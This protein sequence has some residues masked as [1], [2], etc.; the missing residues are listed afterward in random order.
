MKK[1]LSILFLCFLFTVGAQSTSANEVNNG[2]DTQE[3]LVPLADPFILLDGQTYYAYGTHS[4]RGIEVYRSDN[5]KDWSY[6]GLAL[7]KDDSYGDKWFWAPEV[8]NVNGKYY[9]YYSADEHICVAT[10]D[11]PRGPFRQLIQKPMMT[12]EK[13]IDNSLFIDDDGTPY[14]FFVRFNNGNNIWVAELEKDLTTLKMN[15]L[16]SC[17]H[18]SQSWERALGRVNEGPFVIKHKGV[19]YMT[20]SANDFRSPLYGIGCATAT[21]IMGTWIKYADNPLLQNPKGLSGVGH[22]ALFTDKNGQLRIVFHAHYDFTRVHPRC[23]YIG[24]VSFEKGASMDKLCV[25]SGYLVPHLKKPHISLKETS[26][27][28]YRNPVASQSLPD[29]SVI[30]GDDGYFYLFATEDVRN[31]PIYR[32]KNLVNWKFVGTAFSDATRPTFVKEGG[33]WAPDVNKINGKYVLY[34]AMSKWGGEWQCGIGR[35]VSDKVEGP[36]KD[37][38]KLFISS[39]IGVKNSIDPCYVE[40]NGKKYLFWGS[41]HGI[42]SIRLSD[43]GLSLYDKEKPHKVAGTA[44]EAPYVYKRNGH[45]YLF[46]ST[47]TCCDGLNS[48]YTTVVGRSETLMGPYVNKMG[49]AM[50][51]NHHEI[52]IQKNKAFVG[53][54]HNSE[55]VTDLAGNDW[56]LYHAYRTADVNAGRVLMLDKIT[57]DDGWPNVSTS[58]PSL[59]S[60]IPDL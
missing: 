18:V 40:D 46:A 25:D 3:Q 30:K 12:S 45:Y 23:M 42:Y 29:P 34:Y 31:M 4:D 22:H 5:L 26:D 1:Y 58:S 44:Y 16:H 37:L 43:D 47:G 7:N 27:L 50:T 38:G 17:I 59:I 24:S 9:M 32:S 52:V 57:W 36:Y 20:Y 6:V 2:N 8:Y 54:G 14:L 33:L 56:L 35:A 28:I 13:A 39:E 11:D 53:T 15:T 21:N 19:Y 41:F 48:T 60:K 49:Q 51:E 55:I 10:A